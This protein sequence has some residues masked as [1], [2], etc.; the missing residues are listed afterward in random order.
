MRLND[1][2]VFNNDWPLLSAGPTDSSGRNTGDEL[3]IVHRDQLAIDPV[4]F[5]GCHREATVEVRSALNMTDIETAAAWTT[6]TMQAGT[7]T[8]ID[9][10]G[11]GNPLHQVTKITPT[12]GQI[13]VSIAS[14]GEFAAHLKQVNVY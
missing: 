6:F 3:I 9:L 2:H 14:L 12:Q 7:K 1:F 13:F 10:P 4:V 8:R 5:F 11:T